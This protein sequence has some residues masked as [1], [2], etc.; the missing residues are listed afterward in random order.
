M[1]VTSHFYHHFAKPAVNNMMDEHSVL[2]S[3]SAKDM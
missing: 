3:V 1:L 2:Q